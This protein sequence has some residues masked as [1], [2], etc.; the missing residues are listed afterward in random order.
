MQ[1]EEIVY[2][3]TATL[4]NSQVADEWLAWLR[5]GHIAEILAEGATSAEIIALDQPDLTY[6][7]RYRFPSR[8]AFERYEQKIAPR[9]RAEGLKRFPPEKGI[10][11][12]RSTGTVL[13]TLTT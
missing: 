11:Y 10:S 8:Q 12:R 7:V 6:E 2:T 9:L 1:M 3:V 13:T 4:P 5:D